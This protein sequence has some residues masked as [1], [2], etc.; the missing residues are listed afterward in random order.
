[1]TIE[2]PVSLRRSMVSSNY[3]TGSL[4]CNH[5]A[6]NHAKACK[7]NAAIIM[8]TIIEPNKIDVSFIKWAALIAG[9]FVA[10]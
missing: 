9:S 6:I 2:S 10:L 8:K 1:M 5:H 7:V 4:T 3:L